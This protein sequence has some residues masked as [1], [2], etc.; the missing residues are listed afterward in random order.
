MVV[1]GI[2]DQSFKVKGLAG[3]PY[4][5]DFDRD[6]FHVL[7]SAAK[8]AYSEYL[9]VNDSYVIVDYDRN[10]SV[11][12][13]TIEGILDA[14]RRSSFKARIMLDSRLAWF[15]TKFISSNVKLRVLESIRDR[16]PAL[17]DR[18]RISKPEQTPAMA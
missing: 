17:D 3:K 14:K 7:K 12:G 11:V 6:L 18:G 2:L 4:T 10:R 16:L 8:V 9:P 13:Y 1:D 15:G 5:L